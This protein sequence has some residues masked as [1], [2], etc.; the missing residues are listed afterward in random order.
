MKIKGLAVIAIICV[1]LIVWIN[2]FDYKF[3]ELILGTGAK[4]EYLAETISLSYL[5]AFIFYFL[6]VYLVDRNERKTIL[7]FIARS[8]ISIIVIQ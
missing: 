5:A 4:V 1:G 8:V 6:N 3:S 7:P 2:F